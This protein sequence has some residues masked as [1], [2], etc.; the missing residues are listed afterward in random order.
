MD[1]LAIRA[2]HDRGG[3]H[4]VFGYGRHRRVLFTVRRICDTRKDVREDRRRGRRHRV[5][6]PHFSDWRWQCQAGVQVPAREGRG[7]RGIVPH[8]AGSRPA[9]DRPAEYGHVDD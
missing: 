2:Q 1:L 6:A 8:G 4:R 5:R 3:R 7:V 9:G